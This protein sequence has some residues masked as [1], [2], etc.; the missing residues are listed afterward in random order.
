MQDLVSQNK[1]ISLKT[2]KNNE[3]L[4]KRALGSVTDTGSSKM[5]KREVG[6]RE[7][8]RPVKASRF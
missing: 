5:L 6:G 1:Q 3:F 7:H 2:E 4:I 8:L